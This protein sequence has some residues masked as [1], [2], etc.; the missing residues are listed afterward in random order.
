MSNANVVLEVRT[1]F[2]F[3]TFADIAQVSECLHWG[4]SFS[5]GLDSRKYCSRSTFGLY[6]VLCLSVCSLNFVAVL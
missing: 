2:F 5:D 6:P 1:T 4:T 3:L